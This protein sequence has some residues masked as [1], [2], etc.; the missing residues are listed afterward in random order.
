MKN[1]GI[2]SIREAL[3][4]RAWNLCKA[5]TWKLNL[6]F[7][8]SPLGDFLSDYFIRVEARSNF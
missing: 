2:F 6:F 4:P 7:S 8:L 1:A 5:L 3:F